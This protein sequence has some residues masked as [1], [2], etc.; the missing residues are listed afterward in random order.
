MFSI[1]ARNTMGKQLSVRIDDDLEEL[2]EKE[3]AK[4]PYEPSESDIVRAALRDYLQDDGE[5]NTE[6]NARETTATMTAD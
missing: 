3:K 4:S 2:I 5:G 6:G 1:N